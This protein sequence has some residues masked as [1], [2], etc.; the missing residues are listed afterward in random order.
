MV[1]DFNT[2]DTRRHP[3]R[4]RHPAGVWELFVPG[5]GAGA[6]YK[7]EILGADGGCCR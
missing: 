3:M 6:R 4:L 5:V 1:G 2:W 7:Y